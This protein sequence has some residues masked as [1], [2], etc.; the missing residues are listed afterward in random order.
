MGGVWPNLAY[1]K[2]KLKNNNFNKLLQTMDL[3]YNNLKA[4]TNST[5]YNNTNETNHKIMLV[6]MINIS[7]QSNTRIYQMNTYVKKKKKYERDLKSLVYVRSRRIE[8]TDDP[9]VRKLILTLDRLQ[10]RRRHFHKLRIQ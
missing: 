1:V 5:Q 6:L 7:Y 8:F 10:L 9:K 3:S 2:L 4:F